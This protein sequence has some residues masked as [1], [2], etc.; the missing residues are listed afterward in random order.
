[1]KKIIKFFKKIMEYI[2]V[3]LGK[4]KFDNLLFSEGVDVVKSKL[5][6]FID[7]LEDDLSKE[8]LFEY[9][10][11]FINDEFGNKVIVKR[12]LKKIVSYA[13]DKTSNLNSLSK[14]N[15]RRYITMFTNNMKDWYNNNY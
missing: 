2:K 8:R 7:D 6:T 9:I 12:Y 14:S 10:D 3:M 13:K 11:K 5:N 4:I 1:M 15:L